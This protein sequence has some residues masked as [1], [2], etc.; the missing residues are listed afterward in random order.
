VAYPSIGAHI[1]ATHNYALPF[2]LLG[3]LPLISVVAIVI[4]DNVVHGGKAES[5][6]DA[7]V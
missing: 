4:F 1:H 7:V 5:P 2:V 3:I 6:K